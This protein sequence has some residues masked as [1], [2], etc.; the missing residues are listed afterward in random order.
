MH[1]ANISQVLLF[2]CKNFD[3]KKQEDHSSRQLPAYEPP[4]IFKSDDYFLATEAED[5]LKIIEN[6]RATNN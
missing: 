1:F 4:V 5:A 2:I 3:Q 6:D